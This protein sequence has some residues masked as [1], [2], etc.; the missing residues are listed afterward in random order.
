MVRPG[1]AGSYFKSGQLARFRIVWMAFC[2]HDSH[3]MRR[4]RAPSWPDDIMTLGVIKLLSP[5]S[6]GQESA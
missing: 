3:E 1:K 6:E 2:I 5:T 4:A